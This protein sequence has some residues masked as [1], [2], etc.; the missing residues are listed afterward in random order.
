MDN[1]TKLSQEQL[2]SLISD[3]KRTGDGASVNVDDFAKRHL[4]E[5]QTEKLKEAMKNPNL[6]NFLSSP[7][8]KKILDKLKGDSASK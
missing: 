6:M 7:E 1:E 5:K 8:A 3:L 4:N 2:Q